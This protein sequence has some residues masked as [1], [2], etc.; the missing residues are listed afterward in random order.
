[1]PQFVFLLA[2]WGASTSLQADDRRLA[3]L[4]YKMALTLQYLD[5]PEDALKEIKVSLCSAATKPLGAYHRLASR[6]A[7]FVEARSSSL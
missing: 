6:D 1:M 2:T 7:F 3:E 4:H 5:Q